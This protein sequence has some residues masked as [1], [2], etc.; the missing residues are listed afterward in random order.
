MAVPPAR[1]TLAQVAAE[2]GVSKATASKVLNDRPNIAPE[3]RRRVQ[4]AIARLGYAPS[5]GPRRTEA[6]LPLCVVF[7][8]LT[9]VYG[10]R[11]LE[12]VISAARD[13]GVEVLVDAQDVEAGGDRPLSPEWIR[14]QARARRTGIILVTMEITAEQHALLRAHGVHVVH[15]DPVNPLDDGA[16]SVASTN[17]TGG[18]QA[19]Q[20]LLDL[21]HRRIAFAGGNA[22]S[23]P[24]RERLQGYLAALTH[25]GGDVDDALVLQGGFGHQAGVEMAT[26]FLTLDEP[27]TAIFA[28]TDAAALGTLEA[29]RR[30]GLRVPEELSVVG[31]D[32]TYAA[33][34]S[35]PALTTVRQPIVEMGRVA[36]RTL[37]DLASGRRSDFHHMQ[38][39]TQL[40]VREST[41]P[42]AA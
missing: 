3:T 4:D 9:D 14:A 37:L 2:A 23:M 35:A 7:R 15:I 28:V 39:S 6:T 31:F 16:P 29:A 17:F 11:V 19:T 1:T 27:P 38:L 34:T 13:H 8:T 12:G 25:G 20:H 36:V 22:Q 30:E 33:I 42:P 40:V 32:D 10:F 18:M 5:T 24:V 41:A 26:K 21:G